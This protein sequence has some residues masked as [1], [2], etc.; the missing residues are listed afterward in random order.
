MSIK[1]LDCAALFAAAA[2]PLPAPAQAAHAA[3]SV[4]NRTIQ[5]ASA[6]LIA[7]RALDAR[8]AAVAYRLSVG[9]EA[10]CG[11]QV[12]WRSGIELHH[13]TQYGALGAD[14]AR[15]LFGLGSIPAILTLAPAS[16]ADRAGLRPDDW[17]LAADTRPMPNAEASGPPRFLVVQQ[18]TDVLESAFADGEAALLVSRTGI[19]RE[20]RVSAVRGCTSRFQVVPGARPDARADGRFVQL[21]SAMVEL[22]ADDDELAGSLAHELAHNVL[23]H[24]ERLNAAGLQRGILESV[25][26]NARLRR[27]TE[28]EADRYSIY[29]AAAAGFD[30]QG[31]V[32]FL[33]K[34]LRRAEP[35]FQSPTHPAHRDRIAAMQREI[36]RIAQLR[37]AGQPIRPPADL[38]SP[39]S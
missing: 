2:L 23:R 9:A 28:A 19:A 18:S 38:P 15:T 24:R 27:E 32:R 25:G 29:L 1:P 22:A 12:S 11:G 31:A 26:R 4:Q 34:L 3:G 13:I 33:T 8:V 36:D 16:G 6:P 35:V 30:P 37:A 39:A 5:Q 21:T 7:L 20:V 14:Q 17:I 10:L